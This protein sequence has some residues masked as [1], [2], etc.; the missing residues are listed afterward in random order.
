MINK[1]HMR[2][3]LA[4]EG[5]PEHPTSLAEHGKAGLA[6][7]MGFIPDDELGSQAIDVWRSAEFP[8][9]NAHVSALGMATFYNAMTQESS[10]AAN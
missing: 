2:D 1:P 10:S 4:A 8:S 5:A 9:T 3:V 7:A 6:V